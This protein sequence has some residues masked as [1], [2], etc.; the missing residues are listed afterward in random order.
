MN[1]GINDDG[2]LLVRELRQLMD[3]ERTDETEYSYV[4]KNGAANLK[5]LTPMEKADEEYKERRGY[6]GS[7]QK[8]FAIFAELLNAYTRSRKIAG[9]HEEFQGKEMS[10]VYMLGKMSREINQ[11]GTEEDN[12]VDMHGYIKLYAK[13]VY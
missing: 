12:V 11:P 13:E 3:Q 6:R 9:Y 10:L 7:P 4:D 5:P 1:L 2:G 8:E